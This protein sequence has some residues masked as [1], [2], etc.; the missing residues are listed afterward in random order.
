MVFVLDTLEFFQDGDRNFII[1]FLADWRESI[2]NDTEFYCVVNAKDE[3][4]FEVNNIRRVVGGSY[5]YGKR[6]IESLDM[7]D[8]DQVIDAVN[9]RE[10]V[11]LWN[12]TKIEQRVYISSFLNLRLFVK[13]IKARVESCEE[14]HV[15]TFGFDDG[16]EVRLSGSKNDKQLLDQLNQLRDAVIS[17]SKVTIQ[18]EF[19]DDEVFFYISREKGGEYYIS[20]TSLDNLDMLDQVINAIENDEPFT[21]EFFI[22]R[23]KSARSWSIFSTK[24]R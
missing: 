11:L 1:Q 7:L 10:R 8:L 6:S 22:S 18:S 5:Y 24:K 14:L 15:V 23:A 19:L 12:S 9:N 4:W 13:M 17:D 16:F 21:G 2:I 20:R 3:E